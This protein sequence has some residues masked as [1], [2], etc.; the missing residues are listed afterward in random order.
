MVFCDLRLDFL[1]KQ[2]VGAVRFGRKTTG[3]GGLF[4]LVCFGY[5]IQVRLE[6][7]KT[8]PMNVVRVAVSVAFAF[9]I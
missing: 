6:C 8:L 1:K 3:R 9:G 4:C 7:G 2:E 5:C